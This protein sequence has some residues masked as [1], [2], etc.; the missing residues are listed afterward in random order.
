VAGHFT[1]TV[2]DEY[3]NTVIVVATFTNAG[4]LNGRCTPSKYTATTAPTRLILDCNQLQQIVVVAY[5]GDDDEIAAGGPTLKCCN[6]R[7]PN[8]C[9]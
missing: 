6:C 1:M 4:T 7:L 9:S 5:D 3:A 8:I 2:A